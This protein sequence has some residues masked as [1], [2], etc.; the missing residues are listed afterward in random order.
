[1]PPSSGEA[2]APRRRGFLT[3]EIALPDDF[4]RMGKNEIESRFHGGKRLC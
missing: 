4:D 2:A 1:M 3:G